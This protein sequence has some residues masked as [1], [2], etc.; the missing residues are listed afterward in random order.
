MFE[1]MWE[2]HQTSIFFTDFFMWI[3]HFLV[4]SYTGV[5]LYLQIIGTV[6]FAI[7]AILLYKILKNIT[8]SDTA[9][10]A[11]MFFIMFRAKMS[12]FPDF[13]NLQIAFSTLLFL[14][15]ISF[16][17]EQQKKGYLC[18]A[19]IFLCLEILSYPSCLLAWFA[20][21][22]ILFLKTKD[23]RKNIGLFTGICALFGGIYVGYFICRTGPRSF[24]RNLSNIVYSDSHSEESFVSLENHVYGILQAAA[25]LL[26]CAA[27]A[28]IL[29]R[30]V[31]KLL[32]RTADFFPVYGFVL[33]ISEFTFLLL[34]KKTGLNWVSTFNIIPA[35]LM[36][37]SCFSYKQMDEQEK[38]I[39]L[40]GNLF[41]LC[42]LLSTWLLTNL[43]LITMIPYMVLG[44]V[45]SLTALRHRK[46]KIEIFLLAVCAL[47]TM[48]RGLVVS[49]YANKDQ[50]WMV[51]DIRAMI[52]TGPSIGIV[53]DYM[54]YYQTKC[55]KEDHSEFL[56][57]GDSLFLVGNWLFE[58]MEFLLA[59]AD[60]SN[61]STINTPAYND[62]LLDYLELCPNKKPT[63][64][65]VS[66]FYGQMQVSEDTWI[67]KWVNENYETVGEGRYWR[68]YREKSR[69]K[70]NE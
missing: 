11:A 69:S 1:Q 43:S 20:A 3:Y 59:G 46:K 23:R 70:A 50:V 51:Q 19:A 31:R 27:F 63:V 49:G 5:M 24:F 58:P 62:K 60:I 41:A 36:I 9:H 10:F 6:F 67:M 45:V 47:V 57:S 15:L 37:L 14:C 28:W 53:S 12:P 64:V 61:Y 68:Y 16:I 66:C 52:T 4:P 21:V 17:R 18:L 35:F 22:L 29:C 55:D 56:T 39:W 44:G 32:H 25:W 33:L 13:A 30:A 7:I 26:L 38:T 34:Q 8:G 65:A 48:H 54:T 2:P 42:S 40:T